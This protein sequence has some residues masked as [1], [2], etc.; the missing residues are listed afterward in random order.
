MIVMLKKRMKGEKKFFHTL[1]SSYFCTLNSNENN[2]I[3]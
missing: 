1:F 3:I 2:I